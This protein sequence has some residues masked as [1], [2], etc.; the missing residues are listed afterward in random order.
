MAQF[1]IAFVWG[2][3]VSSGAAIGVLGFCVAKELLDLFFGSKRV[4]QWRNYNERL[5]ELLLDRNKLSAAIGEHI[6]DVALVLQ[7]MNERKDD[8]GNEA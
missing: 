3:G 6:K 5:I 2:L 1:W 4:A 8:D 7:M